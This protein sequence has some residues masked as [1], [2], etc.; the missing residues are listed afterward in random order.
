M[1][2]IDGVDKNLIYFYLSVSFQ[3]LFFY[4]FFEKN[5]KKKM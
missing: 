2:K 5:T 3:Y 4:H 1:S